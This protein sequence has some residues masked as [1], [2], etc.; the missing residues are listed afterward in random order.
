MKERKEM[1]DSS[2]FNWKEEKLYLGTEF[3]GELIPVMFRIKF[4]NGDLSADIYNKTRAK[5]NFIKL[6]TEERNTDL[7]SDL[8][9]E[10]EAI[11]SSL[12]S[13]STTTLPKL[14]I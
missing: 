12:V 3:L 7:R 5:E 9:G 10:S 8:K 6:I 2:K 1:I 11:R 14:P 13:F 4:S